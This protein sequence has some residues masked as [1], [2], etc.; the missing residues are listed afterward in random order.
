MI[1]HRAHSVITEFQG[2]IRDKLRRAC[3]SLCHVNLRNALSHAI[4]ALGARG[5]AAR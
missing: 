5:E 2:A 1:L 4:E 3:A